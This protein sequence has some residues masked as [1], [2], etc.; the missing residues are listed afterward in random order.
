MFKCDSCRRAQ[1][2]A[3]CH[4]PGRASQTEELQ[5]LLAE[6]EGTG[7]ELGLKLRYPPVQ[8]LEV[9]LCP[10]PLGERASKGAYCLQQSGQAGGMGPAAA[11]EQRNGL[12]EG[13]VGVPR[14]S[15]ALDFSPLLLQLTE[16]E[17][18]GLDTGLQQADSPLELRDLPEPV[19]VGRRWTHGIHDDGY[20]AGYFESKAALSLGRP[21]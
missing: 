10:L 2:S 15:V 16:V 3:T 5:H 20:A 14:G 8:A 1:G 9:G 6:P 11:F 4:Y 12:P 13:G 7:A 18:L 17:L 21:S 19:F